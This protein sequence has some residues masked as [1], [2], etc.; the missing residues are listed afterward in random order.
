MKPVTNR[1]TGR[2]KLTEMAGKRVTLASLVE[3]ED[4]RPLTMDDGKKRYFF[5]KAAPGDLKMPERK[6][7]NKKGLKI[8]IPSIFKKAEA[9]TPAES[10]PA[11]PDYDDIKSAMQLY[12]EPTPA[13]A[14]AAMARSKKTDE[15]IARLLSASRSFVP[16][17]RIPLPWPR[18]LPLRPSKREGTQSARA[19]FQELITPNRHIQFPRDLEGLPYGPPATGNELMLVADFGHE[20]GDWCRQIDR[21]VNKNRKEM[22]AREER[23]VMPKSK[24]S[25]REKKLERELIVR[26]GEY[27]SW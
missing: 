19:E 16:R 20:N 18:E 9:P 10:T 5:Q 22:K 1:A 8:F 12:R 24:W 23:P 17:V 11:A 13:Q 2:S 3:E 25:N 15:T 26:L 27:P 21:E 4:N 7:G 14:A 6:T